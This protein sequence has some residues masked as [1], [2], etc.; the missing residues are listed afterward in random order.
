MVDT[1]DSRMLFRTFLRAR[2]RSVAI[3]TSVAL[4]TALVVAGG[5]TASAV[6]APA[7]VQQVSV[8]SA[9]VTS[10]ALAP[11]LSL[12]SANR[13]VVEVGV[14]SSGSATAK[15]VTDS[16]GDV[17]T[18]VL[19]FTANDHTEMS[20]WT[21]PVS[22]GAGA[23]P[24]VTVTS[25]AKADIG[26]A[27]LEYSG[28]S[29]AAG[30]GS[31]DVSAQAAGKT[32][33]AAIVSSPATAAVTATNELSLGFYLDSGFGATLTAGAGYVSRVKVAPAGDMELLVED[34]P[35]ASGDTPTATVTTG[36]NTTWL[37]ADVVFAASS[38][39]PPTA[40]DAPTGVMAAAA[41]S[42]ATLNWTVAANGGSSITTYT[43]TPLMNG[44]PQ[45]SSI[46]TGSP[47]STSATITGLMN[48]MSYTFTVSATNVAGTSP[49]SG[50]SN[51]VTPTA[52]AGGSW[53]ALQ[54]WPIA[55]LAMHVLYTGKTVSWDGW[56]QP[57]PSVAWDPAD[58]STFNTINAPDS[59]FCDGAAD[60]PDG[61]LLVIGGYG[62]L[63]TGQIGIVD[64]NIYDPSTGAWTRVADMHTPRWYPTVTE[65]S[66]GRYLAI[67]GNSTNTN[68]WADTPEVYDPKTNVWTALNNV[69]TSSVH[70]V[71]YPFS[72]EVPNGDVFVIGP[73]EDNS[74]LLDVDAQTWTSTGSAGI[75]NGSSVMYRPGK[76]LYSGGAALI[77]TASAA[78]ATTSVID[79]TAPTPL[80]RQTMPMNHAR[81]YHNLLMLADGTVL[82]VGGSTTSDQQVIKTGVLPT[83]IWNPDT[84]MWTDAAPIAT[85]RNYHSTAVLMPDARVLLTGGG[86]PTGLQDAAQYSGQIYTPAY[87]SQGPRPTITSA[88]SGATY[89]STLPIVSP[90]AAAITG[91]NLV[92]L[93]A[94]THQ[95]DMNQHFVTLSF[96]AT[97]GTLNVQAPTSSAVAP[98]GYY[99][100]FILKNGV[101]SVASMVRIAA[102]QTAPAAPSAVT[103]T[104]G[105]GTADVS[106]RAPSDGNSP[107]TSYTVT[108]YSN[109]VAQFP[110]TVSGNPP[111]TSVRISGLTN[112]AGYTFTVTA[113]N[114][115]ASG[116]A[117]TG[118]NLVTP[119]N[120][121]PPAFI[122]S[123]SNKSVG[124]STLSVSPNSAVIAG[125]R[126]IVET[127]IWNYS[128]ST[129]I[130][131]T[132]TAG[133]VYTKL[134]SQ[135]GSDGTELDVW[136][137]PITAGGGTKPT[138]TVSTNAGAD[139]GI[140]MLE[141]SGIA[142]GTAPIDVSV[143]AGGTTS[144]A[145][146]IRS[147]PTSAATGNGEIALGFYAD[148]GFGAPVASISDWSQRVNLTPNT[149]MDLA[150][151]DQAVPTNGATPNAG[152]T[153][154]PNTSW[155]AATLVFK[156]AFAS[157]PTTP[158]APAAV[159]ATA[160]NAAAALTWSAPNDGGSPISTYT[161][162][163]YANSAVVSVK[164][165]PA[166]S[167]ATTVTGLTNGTGYNFSVSA[168]NGI[169]HGPESTLSNTVSPTAVVA[170]A[171][172]QQVSA[173]SGS[174]ASLAVTPGAALTSGNRL[175]VEVATWS[176]SHGTV[177]AVTDAAGDVYTEVSHI[178]AADGTELSIWSAPVTAGAGARPVITATTTVKGDVGLAAL[179]YSGLSAATAV[180]TSA[181]ATGKTS[182]AAQVGSGL[183][184]A[185]TTPTGL[186]LGFYADSGFGTALTSD[187]G[188]RSRV[189]LSPFGDVDMLVEDAVVTAGATPGASFGTGKNTVWLAATLVF[190]SGP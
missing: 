60:L 14:W 62:S 104:A 106:W 33:A 87:L 27:V 155:L 120:T 15:T 75:F 50:P 179:E 119:S 54:T 177:S 89:G 56:Q 90:D 154:G 128:H 103:A 42:A 25:S 76:I 175:I 71:E 173:R 126:I 144:S 46:V 92:S 167:T 29:G 19:H 12:T 8:H 133:N 7:F 17:F 28:L 134:S 160:Q 185:T 69:N 39:A 22:T 55:P 171:F 36:S 48:N 105:N 5:G 21:A 53:S 168:T 184:P 101:P 86:H 141:Y 51:A 23:K 98:P 70:E 57:Q 41:D 147:G 43:I 153:T 132:D 95:I 182:A 169:G 64:T 100:L 102:T 24:A 178:V 159:V 13:L 49:Q 85:A 181:K 114:S 140:S 47:P 84:E 125:N 58:P 165:V 77:N 174:S 1:G 152:F 170:P 96:T 81:I 34:K 73:E 115:V 121:P 188:Y 94:T 88:P 52:A 32:S 45:P 11:T 187:P 44:V 116:P 113:T 189:N 65:L 31:V 4:V 80:W 148:S 135:V 110:T 3:A 131:V 35:V 10:V 109:G 78:K 79:T 183:T 156:S 118:S 63:S 97:G 107:I 136:S 142:G 112:G 190:P 150:V 158:S 6:A 37:M 93:A 20:I 161:V 30:A 137:A 68:T 146:T 124:V 172:V 163:T 111:A 82:A 127:G 26:A 67:S 59:V 83:E 186:A 66:D 38:T 2:R 157:P 139:I 122:Q 61:R 149:Q 151:A 180:D 72:Y 143:R 91:V 108:P 117:S 123:A 99:M 166:T 74:H 130:A 40:P 129:A 18:E 145:A 162:T 176:S 138:V 9:N 16:A 164:T